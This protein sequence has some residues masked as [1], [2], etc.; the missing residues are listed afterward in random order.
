M[1][2]PTTYG[3]ALLL[4]ILTMLCWGSWANTMKLTGKWR[5][6]LYYFDYAFGVLAA[7]IIAAFTFGS[8]EMTTPSTEVI[9]FSFMDNILVAS[10]RQ[11]A[12]AMAGGVVFNLAN[13]L[14]VA[15]IAIAGMAVAFPIGIGLALIIGVA[16][17][18]LIRPAGNPGLLFGGS[19]VVLL[20]IIAC[21]LAHSLYQKKRAPSAETTATGARTVAKGARTR[22]GTSIKG[23]ILSLVSGIFMGT[24]FPLVEMSKSGDIGLGPYAAA[25]FFA[26]GVVLSTP[27]FNAFFMNLPVEGPTVSIREYFTGTVKQHALGWLGGIIWCTG[28]ICSFVAAS[29]PKSVNVGPAVSYAI[30]QGATL[31]SMLWGLLVWKEFAGASGA[32]WVRI[33]LTLVLFAIGLG[34][35]SIA[36][37]YN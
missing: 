8:I 23:V 27:F 15:A 16:L 22:Q 6:E 36:P 21:A 19:G 10:K 26:V 37:L 24:F 7:A 11:M 1:M 30:G 31:V 34:M 28:A 25:F 33:I 32:V 18:Y 29:A 2:L 13:M 20:A 9:G 4:T 17:N 35:V 3:V 14:L 5:F 12:L